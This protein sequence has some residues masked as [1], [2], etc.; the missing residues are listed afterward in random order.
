MKTT[1]LLII[2][3][4]CVGIASV[5]DARTKR[6]HRH[7]RHH[8]G[9]QLTVAPMFAVPT[10]AGAP[11]T[12]AVPV[13]P[14]APPPPSGDFTFVETFNVQPDSEAATLAA[15]KDIFNDDDI[16]LCFRA[17]ETGTFTTSAGTFTITLVPSDSGPTYDVSWTLAAG[18]VLEGV[19]FKGGSEGGNWYS[20]GELNS[21]FGNGHTP[22]TGGSGMFAGLSHL[23]FFCEPGRV[24]DGGSTVALLGLAL[25]GLEGMRR[26]VR[27]RKD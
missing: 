27:G 2:G 7:H 8:R 6:H 18:Q 10:T 17:E 26:L 20:A 15:A 25:G 13:T 23:D 16:V 4:L 14:L 9:H 19:Q 24:P 11:T 5:A 3:L 1:R 22:V 21:G 12:A